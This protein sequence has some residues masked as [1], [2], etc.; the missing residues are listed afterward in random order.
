MKDKLPDS[1][2]IAPPYDLESVGVINER[3]KG[4]YR[5]RRIRKVPKTPVRHSLRNLAGDHSINGTE[6][7]EQNSPLRWLS[8]KTGLRV[9]KNLLYMGSLW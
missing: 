5:A 1:A 3:M 9:K 7:E 2:P 4:V 8:K 6:F